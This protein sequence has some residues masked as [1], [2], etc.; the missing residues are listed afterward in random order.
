MKTLLPPSLC[1][2]VAQIAQYGLFTARLWLWV[3][4]YASCDMRDGVIHRV[5]NN[6]YIPVLLGI[7]SYSY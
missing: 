2:S 6:G 3:M 4:G 5:I 1:L 7:S